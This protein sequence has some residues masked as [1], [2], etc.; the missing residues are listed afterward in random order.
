[1]L[2]AFLCF[3]R[4]AELR[5][6]F[7]SQNAGVWISSFRSTKKAEQMLDFFR[8]GGG[9]IRTPATGLPVLTI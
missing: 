9:E 7:A 6:G 2:R 1:M 4:Y 3:A 8:G 5:A